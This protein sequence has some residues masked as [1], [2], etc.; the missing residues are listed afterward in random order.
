MT[1]LEELERRLE[2]KFQYL[3][4]LSLEKERINDDIHLLK[5]DIVRLKKN[6]QAES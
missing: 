3:R 2:L 6:D 1:E 4:L 5:N